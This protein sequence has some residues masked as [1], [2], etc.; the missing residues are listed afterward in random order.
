[1]PIDPNIQL[2]WRQGFFKESFFSFLQNFEKNYYYRWIF[3]PFVNAYKQDWFR[4]VSK[5]AHRFLLTL[6]RVAWRFVNCFESYLT[7][8]SQLKQRKFC[9]SNK[10]GLSVTTIQ[11]GFI[12]VPGNILSIWLDPMKLRKIATKKVALNN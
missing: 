7:M 2:V 6:K 8:K 10:S 11:H 9:V 12:R 5:T 1:M 3:E 4:P